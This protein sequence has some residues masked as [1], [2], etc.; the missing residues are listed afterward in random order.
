M[1]CP[2]ANNAGILGSP[3]CTS[4]TNIGEALLYLQK[5]TKTAFTSATFTNIVSGNGWVLPT[6]AVYSASVNQFIA[7]TAT[8]DF[9]TGVGTTIALFRIRDTTNS[10][11]SG[12]TMQ[13]GPGLVLNSNETLAF[14]AGFTH[15]AQ[16]T[17]TFALQVSVSGAAGTITIGPGAML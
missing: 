11:N 7:C 4:Q 17:P 6:N 14:M 12:Y 9:D 2:N 8:F 5:T 1:Y 13:L 16:A 3:Q 15:T 10:V